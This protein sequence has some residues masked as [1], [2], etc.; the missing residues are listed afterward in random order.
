MLCRRC[1]VRS[2]LK[3]FFCFFLKMSLRVVYSTP[4]LLKAS[5]GGFPVVVVVVVIVLYSAVHRLLIGNPKP[6]NN[7]IKETRIVRPILFP[8]TS[9][10]FFCYRTNHHFFPLF[11]LFSFF[12]IDP[13]S[14]IRSSLPSHAHARACRGTTKKES[15]I[16]RLPFY[17]YLEKR[18]KRSKFY[19]SLHVTLALYFFVMAR[20]PC[21]LI[22]FRL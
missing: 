14:S 13:F 8:P 20:G 4:P 3:I 10:L 6:N 18:T 15:V 16:P 2:S 7:N 19:G 17:F 22:Q 12:F 11:P 21:S 5:I 1:A 9:S